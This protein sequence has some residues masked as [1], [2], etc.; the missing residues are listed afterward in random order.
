MPGVGKSTTGVLLA[1][2]TGRAFVDTDLLIQSEAGRSLQDLID[3]DGLADFRGREER[4]VSSLACRNTVIATGGS[5]V[6]GEAS[7]SRLHG[8]GIIVFLRLGLAEIEQRIGDPGSRGLVRRPGQSIADLY[9]ERQPLYE[10]HADVTVPCD[11]L[12][13]A[14]VVDRIVEALQAGGWSDG[15]R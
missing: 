9:A 12:V 13:P 11:G 3:N 4:I 5:V 8:L 6:Y 14:R 2:R 15:K 7:M 10:R 1:K